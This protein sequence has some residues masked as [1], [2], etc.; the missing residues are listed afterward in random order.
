MITCHFHIQCHP[1]R[2]E[3]EFEAMQ[4]A[5]DQEAYVQAHR[6]AIETATSRID[7][8]RRNG[9]TLFQAIIDYMD[10]E[11]VIEFA[12]DY[13]DRWLDGYSEPTAEFEN[14]VHRAEGAFLALCEALLMHEPARGVQLWR[15]LSETLKTRYIGTAG[16]DELVHMP[17]RVPDSPEVNMLRDDV[18]ELEYDRTD[19]LALFNIAIAASFNGKMEWLNEVIKKKPGFALYME[20][21]TCDGPGGFSCGPFTTN[22]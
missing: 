2:S 7:E 19:D 18:A 14:R 10:F 21:N 17:L 4:L 5:L 11:P 22:C 20:A 3:N 13:V 12:P 6:R 8:V 1:R 16:V 15:V 9:V